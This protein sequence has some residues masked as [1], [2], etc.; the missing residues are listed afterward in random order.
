MLIR[1]VP[2]GDPVA[3]DLIARVQEEYV[4][5]YGG[6]DATPVDPAEFTA[7]DG[8][9]LVAYDGPAVLGCGGWRAHGPGR[10]ELKRMYVV[11]QARRR[12]VA[13][14]LL[15]ELERSA[16]AAGRG[17]LVLFTGLAQPEAIAL[18][19]ARGYRPMPGFGP[20]RDFPEARYYSRDLNADDPAPAE[21]GPGAPGSLQ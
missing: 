21:Q 3:Q 1:A 19:E 15:T 20:Y 4:L 11:P 8:V 5:R 9:F 18:Y 6:P 14:A 7:P 13:G 17:V 12:G 16:A 10:A 2:F